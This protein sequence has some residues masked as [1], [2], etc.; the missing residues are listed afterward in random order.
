MQALA[1][2]TY[3]QI[4][5][6][7]TLP[8]ALSSHFLQGYEISLPCSLTQVPFRT[9]FIK[10]PSDT[11]TRLLSSFGDYVGR[12]QMIDTFRF[13]T[14]LPPKI[15]ILSVLINKS[16]HVIDLFWRTT[17]LGTIPW[18]SHENANKQYNRFCSYGFQQENQNKGKFWLYMGRAC[19]H[20]DN[21]S[22]LSVNCTLFFPYYS[23]KEWHTVWWC[24]CTA[25]A[26]RGI[27]LRIDDNFKEKLF[28][29]QM[30][31][32]IIYCSCFI[33][34]YWMLAVLKRPQQ[35]GYKT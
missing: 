26:S 13:L 7:L 23:W 32:Q 21:L 25:R 20:P 29:V 3:L 24:E 6:F 11:L 10:Q 15:K 19:F 28:F 27:V 22:T 35:E 17:P 30:P 14:P 9:P 33:L 16:S 4:I 5:S 18:D 8:I 12:F 34:I 31:P 2:R 1:R